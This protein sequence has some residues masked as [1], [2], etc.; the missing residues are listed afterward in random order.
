MSNPVR[1][2]YLTTRLTFETLA[3]LLVADPTGLKAGA[4]AFVQDLDDD[5]EPPFFCY[6]PTSAATVS[7]PDIVAAN[8]AAVGRWVN[9]TIV[10][11]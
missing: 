6:L 9:L 11:G 8:G 1:P 2:A 10:A 3:D 7:S 5:S 4:M